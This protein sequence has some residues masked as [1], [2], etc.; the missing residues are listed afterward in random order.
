MQTIGAYRVLHRGGGGDGSDWMITAHG[1]QNC[2]RVCADV[3]QPG[4][5]DNWGVGF[6]HTYGSDP[7]YLKCYDNQSTYPLNGIRIQFAS[8]VGTLSLDPVLP[9]MNVT[10]WKSCMGI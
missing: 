7:Y 1:A 8:Q 6:P 5:M 10:D 3:M 4:G 2:S 9:R